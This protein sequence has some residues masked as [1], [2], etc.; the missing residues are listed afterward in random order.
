M[1]SDMFV[2]VRPDDMVREGI[3]SGPP[4]GKGSRGG[5]RGLKY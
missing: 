4:G 1:P 5:R 3:G 2:G